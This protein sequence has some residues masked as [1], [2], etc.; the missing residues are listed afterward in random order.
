VKIKTVAVAVLFFMF[1][2]IFATNSFSHDGEE[3]ND[4][5]KHL[6]EVYKEGSGYSATKKYEKR[7][8]NT[9]QTMEEGS[10]MQREMKGM[11]ARTNENYDKMNKDDVKMIEKKNHG[12]GR[13]YEKGSKSMRMPTN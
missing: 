13:Y 10:G 6:K 7:K 11:P 2:C 1:A 9:Q 4:A 3:H 8:E 12:R 5:P